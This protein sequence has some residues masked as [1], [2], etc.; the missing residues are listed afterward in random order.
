MRPSLPPS[1]CRAGAA[2]PAGASDRSLAAADGQRPALVQ[3]GPSDGAGGAAAAPVRSGQHAERVGTGAGAHRGLLAG[4]DLPHRQPVQGEGRRLGAAGVVDLDPDGRAAARGRRPPAGR[5]ARARRGPG[6]ASG[7]GQDVVGGGELPVGRV[8]GI[9]RLGRGRPGVRRSGWP[10]RCPACSRR[11]AARRPAARGRPPASRG[12]RAAER[13]RA[14]ARAW[15][16]SGSRGSAPPCRPGRRCGGCRE[17]APPAGG[18]A[19]GTAGRRPAPRRRAGPTAG[20][21]VARRSLRPDGA[22]LDQGAVDRA[23]ELLADPVHLGLQRQELIDRRRAGWRCCRTPDRSAGRLRCE[24]ASPPPPEPR[25]PAAASSQQQ[26]NRRQPI[27]SAQYVAASRSS[28][29][30]ARQTA[31]WLM[32]ARRSSILHRSM[33]ESPSQDRCPVRLPDAASAAQA[34]DPARPGGGARHRLRRRGRRLVV[35]GDHLAVHPAGWAAAWPPG[36]TTTTTS[37]TSTTPAIPRFVLATKAEHGA[38]PEMVTP[39]IVAAAG[40]VDTVAVHVDLDGLYAGAKWV[41]GGD[42]ALP[43]RR[44]RRPRGR[45]PPGRAGPHRHPH[46]PR[47]ARALP[48]HQPQAPDRAV[49]AGP[50]PGAPPLGGDRGGRAAD[51]SR[52]STRP[53]GIA[54]R[55]RVD[56]QVAYVRPTAAH[57]LRQDRAAAAGPAAGRGGG[58]ARLGLALHRRGL[59]VGAGLRQAVRAGRRH[60]HPGLG[61]RVAPGRGA[62]EAAATATAGPDASAG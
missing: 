53:S 21:Q 39:E 40:P 35:R 24:R 38:C 44:R 17:S 13:R 19:A 1:R 22:Q 28:D 55:Y 48:R 51:R 8:G 2:P 46:R 3:V 16:S 36:S 54:E 43:G 59:R 14:R 58:G 31:S 27:P 25:R 26:Q 62:G 52:C 34:G 33:S 45:H 29:A 61:P 6:S 4:R 11:G 9:G 57:T 42:R 60:A 47:P 50:H 32:P 41:L 56:G 18:P 12:S 7:G 30:A 20:G 37:A 23:G 15:P 5:R 49:P 10:V